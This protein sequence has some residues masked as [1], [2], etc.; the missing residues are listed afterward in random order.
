MTLLRKLGPDP[1]RYETR[2]DAADAIDRILNAPPTLK[3]IS[4]A[5]YLGIDIERTE[6]TKRG[7]STPS[8][9]HSRGQN[10]ETPSDRRPIAT[11]EQRSAPP[12]RRTST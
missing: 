9:P 6:Y 8:T 4:Y 11:Q 5:R 2:E 10:D 7:F 12:L 3:Q 1:N